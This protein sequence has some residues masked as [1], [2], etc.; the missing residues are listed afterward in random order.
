MRPR[1]ILLAGAAF[2]AALHVIG[3]LLGAPIWPLALVAALLTLAAAGV[4]PD[5]PGPATAGVLPDSPGPTTAGV[6]PDSPG[7]TTVGVLPDSP[8]PTAIGVFPDSPGLA[9]DPS[10]WLGAVALAPLI[11]QAALT[12]P[13]V[14]TGD[15]GWFVTTLASEPPQSAVLLDALDNGFRSAGAL[16]LFVAVLLIAFRPLKTNKSDKSGRWRMLGLAKP[17]QGEARSAKSG[18][19]KVRGSAEP[20]EEKSLG[21]AEPGEGQALGPAKSGEGEALGPAKSGEG[22]ALGSAKSGG[23]E[24]RGTAEPGEGKAESAEPGEGE[25]L[26]SA[27][28]GGGEARGTAEPGEGEARETA[29]SGQGKALGTLAAAAGMWVA[30]VVVLVYAVVRVVALGQIDPTRNGV[31]LAA[32]VV[33]PVVFGLSAAGLAARIVRRGRRWPGV[34]GAFLLVGSALPMIDSTLDALP[35]SYMIFEDSTRLFGWDFL[36]PSDSV[37]APV[38]ALTVAVQLT[39][40]VLLI[41]GRVFRSKPIRPYGG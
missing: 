22:E 38:P 29:A 39:G 16:L 13:R 15:Y 4:L 26:G 25:A 7:P 20:G 35:S 11:L 14:H 27:Q 3:V 32:A 6:L 34:L 12:V 10:R 19:A 33:V 23:G 1:L 36:T 2:L 41:G 28:P 40:L 5:S 9:A 21:S 31:V 8:G 17:G 24:A 18:A 37:P 30:G